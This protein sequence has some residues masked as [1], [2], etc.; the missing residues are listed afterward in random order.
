MGRTRQEGSK[1]L[2]RVI[3]QPR[4]VRV[5]VTKGSNRMPINISAASYEL[6]AAGFER[7]GYRVEKA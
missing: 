5:F 2:A 3:D 6:I 1:Q 7:R 4:F